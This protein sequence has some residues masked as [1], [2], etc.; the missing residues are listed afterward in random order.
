MGS[1]FQVTQVVFKQ[2]GWNKR[3]RTASRVQMPGYRTVTHWF[4]CLPATEFVWIAS[5]VSLVSLLGLNSTFFSVQLQT[6]PQVY[7]AGMLILTAHSVRHWLFS[8]G[9]WLHVVLSCF[10][11]TCDWHFSFSVCTMVPLPLPP[12]FCSF[13]ACLPRCKQVH[14]PLI[15]ASAGPPQCGAVWG[16]G[17]HGTRRGF[18]IQSIQKR[19]GSFL[20]KF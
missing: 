18:W 5:L 15:P 20:A 2:T 13:C 1:T 8:L 4:F 10:C 3:K 19:P 7:F 11:Q 9:A 14:T 12:P 16:I 17:G 6:I